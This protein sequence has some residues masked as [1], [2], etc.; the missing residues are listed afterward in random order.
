MN[1]RVRLFASLREAAGRRELEL[2]CPAGARVSD[3]LRLLAELYPN[4]RGLHTA[5]VAVNLEYVGP[6]FELRDG[7]ELAAIP[8]VSGG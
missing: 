7:D 3:A 2:E 6:D 4:L 5:R 1:I 8:P